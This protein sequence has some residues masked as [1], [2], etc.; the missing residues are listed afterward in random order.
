[1]EA[2]KEELAIS[3]APTRETSVERDFDFITPETV[4]THE[5][6]IQVYQSNRFIQAVKMALDVTN[7]EYNDEDVG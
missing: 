5:V 1:M 2:D 6:Y 7:G 3:I 4:R